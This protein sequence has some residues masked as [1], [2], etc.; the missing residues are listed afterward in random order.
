MKL[1]EHAHPYFAGCRTDE[2]EANVLALALRTGN[3]HAVH[4]AFL[5]L[6]GLSTAT[7]VKR[8]NA[9][10]EISEQNT[11]RGITPAIAALN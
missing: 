3:P 9:A 4:L 2:P 7:A 8:S 11:A 5:A 10:D 1:T 6:L